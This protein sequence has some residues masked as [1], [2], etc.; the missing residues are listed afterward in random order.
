MNIQS[1]LK[2]LP[3]VAALAMG[4][5][6]APMSSMAGDKD[7][8]HGSYSHDAGSHSKSRSD[9]SH[10]RER[11]ADRHDKRSY[12]GDRH[13]SKKHGHKHRKSRHAHNHRGHKYRHQGHNPV[14]VV[15]NH[16]Y[17]PER[18]IALDDLRFMV[19]IHTGNFDLIFRD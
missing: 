12:R 11:H 15:N 19:G 13:H 2:I 7:R 4:L 6:L 1:N 3:V 16:G 9:K 5:A 14:Y 10:K 8:G 17:Y 18:Y